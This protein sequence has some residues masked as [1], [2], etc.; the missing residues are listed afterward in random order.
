MRKQINEVRKMQQLAG[1]LKETSEQETM[2]HILS[3]FNFAIDEAW[4]AIT[5][6]GQ[7]PKVA[8]KYLKNEFAHAITDLLQNGVQ[9]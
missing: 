4:E 8:A 1:V 9:N 3:D 6:T 7:V 2:L 5:A